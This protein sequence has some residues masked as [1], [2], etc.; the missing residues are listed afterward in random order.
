M[1][2]IKKVNYGEFSWERGIDRIADLEILEDQYRQGYSMSTGASALQN[3]G[4]PAIH[5]AFQSSLDRYKSTYNE[6]MK[7]VEFKD[8][9]EQFQ[10]N[11]SINLPADDM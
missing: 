11:F 5:Q 7:Y 4:D 8:I 1:S 6:N 3:S 2:D 10:V 9:W